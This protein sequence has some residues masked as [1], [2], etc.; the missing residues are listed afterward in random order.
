[1]LQ[2]T[3]APHRKTDGIKVHSLPAIDNCKKN[4]Q[5]ADAQRAALDKRLGTKLSGGF[6]ESILPAYCWPR[7]PSGS[8]ASFEIGEEKKL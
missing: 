4:Q 6:V 8:G 3:P 1:L 5:H 7:R 2:I